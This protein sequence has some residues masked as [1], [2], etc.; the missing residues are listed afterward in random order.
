[1]C[2]KLPAFGGGCGYKKVEGIYGALVLGLG[3]EQHKVHRLLFGLMEMWK[4]QL[5][6]CLKA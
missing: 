6:F 2:L 5:S 4:T 1:V 3:D